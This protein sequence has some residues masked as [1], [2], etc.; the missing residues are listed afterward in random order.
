[1]SIPTTDLASFS[2]SVSPG[3]VEVEEQASGEAPPALTSQKSTISVTSSE[4][5]GTD[6]HCEKHS[7]VIDMRANVVS[8]M[9]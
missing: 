8:L 9:C 6:S 5:A 7:T 1:M 3:E 2:L 4:P